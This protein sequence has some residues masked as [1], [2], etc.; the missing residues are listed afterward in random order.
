MKDVDLDSGA[1]S[2][3][4]RTV[5]TGVAAAGVTACGGVPMT[6]TEQPEP[7]ELALKA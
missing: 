7:T 2:F 5:L 1:Q 3:S 6:K 4:R